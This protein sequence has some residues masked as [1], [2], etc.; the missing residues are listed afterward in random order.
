MNSL[1]VL[2]ACAACYGAPD[3]AQTHGMNM[4]ILSML[5]VTGFV[6]SGFGGM[7]FYFARRARR[8]SDHDLP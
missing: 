4:G 5:G 6:L 1:V 8:Y 2:L 3:A 7:I